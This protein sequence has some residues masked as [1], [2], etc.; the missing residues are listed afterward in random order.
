MIKYIIDGY[1]SN[2]QCK[3]I[4]EKLQGKTFMNFNIE[5]GGIAGNNTIIVSS[6]VENYSD[7]ELKEMFIYSALTE[8]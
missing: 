8:F 6:N 1:F 7:E 4:K 2:D 3:K 5:Y